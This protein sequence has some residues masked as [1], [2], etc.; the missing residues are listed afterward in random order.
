[1]SDYK[2][3]T[4]WY[5]KEYGLKEENL[6][7]ERED[8]WF[9][10]YEDEVRS[11]EE[12]ETLLSQRLGELED[13]IEQGKLV[14]IEPFIRVNNNVDFLKYEIVKPRIYNEI[15][16]FAETKEQAEARL[17]ELKGGTNQNSN[18]CVCCG[19]VI[20]EGNQV[21]P[22]CMENNNENN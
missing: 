3:L 7:K 1:M 13:M 4:K 14:S 22:N 18:T 5:G 15:I 21:C 6:S 17:K 8:V 2:R 11:L 20:P 10:G 12:E 16:R 9:G 19:E